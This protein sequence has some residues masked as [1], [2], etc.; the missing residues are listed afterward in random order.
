MDYAVVVFYLVLFVVISGFVFRKK[1][2]AWSVHRKLKSVSVPSST[3]EPAV[4]TTRLYELDKIFGPFGSAAA[5]PSALYAQPQFIEATR[6]L[7]APAVSLAVLLQYVEG[8]SWSLASAALTALKNRREA[9]AAAE[10]VLKH[11]EHFSPWTM[12]F[13]LE[14]LGDTEPRVPVGAPIA[15]ARDWWIDNRWMPNIIRDYLVRCAERGDIA[16]FG[17]ALSTV[18][19]APHDVIRRFLQRITHPFATTLIQE[20]DDVPPALVPPVVHTSALTSVG[21][22]WSKQ[23]DLDVLVEPDGWRKSFALAESTLRQ[24]PPRS[25]LVSG[26]PLVG[27]TSFLQLLAQRIAA[28]GWSVFQASGADLQADQIYI[29]QLE[30]RI[31]Q[32]IEELAKGHRMIWYIPDI[33]QLAM[34]G[35][36]PGPERDHARSDHSVDLR[37]PAAGLVR[38]KPEGRRAAIPDQAVAARLVR[39]RDDRAVVAARNPELSAR[40]GRC[41]GGAAGRA[42]PSR[43]RQGRARYCQPIPRQRRPAGL[44]AAH[45]QTERNPRRATAGD[46]TAPR[47]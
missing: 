37:R 15:R 6:L 9:N 22:F 44:G 28:D 46:H 12:Y 32:V 42:F 8:N 39:D 7:G 16:T 18:S 36:H 29:G 4:L 19:T 10:R 26:D 3:E 34:S 33:V 43:L 23:Q 38:G 11:C 24:N 14:L 17:P 21:Q 41:H 2:R 5:H 47:A 25:L 35:R 30:G 31:R 20:L 40:R 27:K 1:L 45:A 13:A